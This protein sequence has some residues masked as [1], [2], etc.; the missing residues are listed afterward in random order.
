MNQKIVNIALALAIIV[1]LILNFSNKKL[2]PS[3]TKSGA[4]DAS[5]TLK[6]A[7]V[8]LDSLQA[9]YVFYQEQMLEFDRKKE[10]ADR[11]LNNAYQ[12]ID[13]ER[14]SFLKKGESITQAEGENFQRVYQ[15][16]MQNLEEQKKVLENNIAAEGMKIMEELKKRMNTYLEDYNKSQKYSYILS[17]SNSMN[18]LFYKDS[19]YN[20]TNEVVDGLNVAYKKAKTNK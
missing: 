14:I 15:G 20:I 18:V 6:I 5:S 3:P 10:A 12:K 2:S 19:T 13:A 11:D 9:K 8:D 16:K 7:Y 4:A 17:Y 1:L